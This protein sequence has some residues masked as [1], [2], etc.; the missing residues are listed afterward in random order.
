[1]NNERLRHLA[2]SFGT[3]LFAAYPIVKIVES[4]TRWQIRCAGRRFEGFDDCYNDYLPVLEFVA[5][6]IYP[7]FIWLF[8]RYAFSMFAPPAEDRRLQW[9]WANSDAGCD[10]FPGFL[11]GAL[12]GLLWAIWNIYALPLELIFWKIFAYWI[13]CAA[14]FVAGSLVSWRKSETS[15]Q[16]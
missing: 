11:I 8:A 2:S 13:I 12:I 6:L 14:W 5:L 15:E 3:L 1:M 10:Y 16:Y 9:R 4:N 7:L